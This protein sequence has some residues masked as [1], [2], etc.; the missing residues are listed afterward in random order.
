MEGLN[1][2]WIKKMQID[3][4]TARISAVQGRGSP[5]FRPDLGNCGVFWGRLA[6]RNASARPGSRQ[7]AAF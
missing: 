1:E 7:Q 5:S 2:Q 4:Y 3:M 6:H